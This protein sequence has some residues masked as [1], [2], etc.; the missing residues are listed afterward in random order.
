MQTSG[1]DYREVLEIALT[2]A[3]VARREV[4]Q[5]WRHLFIASPKRRQ[6][7]DAPPCTPHQCGLDEIVA[8]DVASERLASP[9]LRQCRCLRERLYPDDG[10]VA[11]IVALGAVPPG[12]AGGD[13]RSVQAAGELLDAA[14]DT[15]GID[16][17][18]KRLDQPGA[19]ISLDGVNQ[20]DD[21][22]PAHE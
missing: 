8:K 6:H 1:G 15:S 5:R 13:H 20:P 21:G 11:P 12:D 9:K 2:P 14:K 4:K 7:V 3:P 16:D 19:R 22:L 10:V 18:G 17:H